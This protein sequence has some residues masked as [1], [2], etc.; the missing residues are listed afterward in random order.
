MSVDSLKLT[1]I[2][3]IL[4]CQVIHRTN[5]Q[6]AGV[7]TEFSKNN[8]SYYL[9]V[10][11][12]EA[13]KWS[14]IKGHREEGETPKECAE[15]EFLE[16]AGRRI[17]LPDDTKTWSNR[18]TLYFH[19]LVPEMFSPQALDTEEIRQA[20]WFSHLELCALDPAMCNS[21]LK[22]FIASLDPLPDDGFV[23]VVK[24]QKPKR[25]RQACK[26]FMAGGCKFGASCRFKHC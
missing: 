12:D 23:A 24:K 22:G 21:G 10:L 13:G 4:T 3:L 15:R 2:K 26:A 20:K 1:Q 7:I 5:M 16:E 14:L 18:D 19:L 8:S 9:L 6:R 25:G 11:G 17:T